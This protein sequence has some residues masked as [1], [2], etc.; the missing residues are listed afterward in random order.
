[1]PTVLSQ[2][3]CVH[4][5]PGSEMEF[6]AHVYHTALIAVLNLQLLQQPNQACTLNQ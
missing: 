4:S 2:L 3:H 1:M 5:L 6:Q